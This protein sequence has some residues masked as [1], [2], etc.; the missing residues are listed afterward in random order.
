MR[1][2]D[3]ALALVLATAGCMTAPARNIAPP[4]LLDFYK[5]ADAYQSSAVGRLCADP[6]LSARVQ[7]LQGRLAAAKQAIVA[8]Y[9]SE[10]V[11]AARVAVVSKTADLCSNRAA[12]GIAVEQFEKAV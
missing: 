10:Q 6:P 1:F 2:R 7:A 8:R 3:A 9:G 4:L 5:D 12:A 11:E